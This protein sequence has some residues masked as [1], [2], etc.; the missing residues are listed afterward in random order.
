[1]RAQAA[2]KAGELTELIAELTS[3]RRALEELAG[4]R[5]S[6]ACPMVERALGAPEGGS[7]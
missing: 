6:G 1:L 3:R 2:R 5:C 7:T 4:C